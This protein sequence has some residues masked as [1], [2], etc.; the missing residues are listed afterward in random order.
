MEWENVDK[1]LKQQIQLKPKLSNGLEQINLFIKENNLQVLDID[2][3]GLMNEF[4]EWFSDV[5]ESEPIPQNI[6]S[7]YFGIVSLTMEEDGISEQN[8][9]VY[10]SGSK[11][12]PIQ[13]TDWA[14]D[15]E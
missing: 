1:I 11:S 13:D 4:N 5:L 6:N 14:C 10:I 12:T 9:A 7:I 2:F 3:E 15:T 8:T